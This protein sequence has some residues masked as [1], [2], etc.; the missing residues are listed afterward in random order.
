MGEVMLLFMSY[1]GYPISDVDLGA[2]QPLLYDQT[3]HV[4][5]SHSR[6]PIVP[7]AAPEIVGDASIDA[8]SLALV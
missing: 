4:S 1:G 3:P 2:V 8:A 6:A 5:A 7:L